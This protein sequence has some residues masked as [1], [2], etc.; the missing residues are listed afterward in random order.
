MVGVEL[1][2]GGLFLGLLLAELGEGLF[3]P[4]Q[5]LDEGVAGSLPVLPQGLELLLL[6][7]GALLG[8]EG[9]ELVQ[10]HLLQ[11]L[12]PSVRWG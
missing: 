7:R 3:D 10:G 2:L 11:H 4:V 5:D 12:R 1:E 9:V 8:L 6:F